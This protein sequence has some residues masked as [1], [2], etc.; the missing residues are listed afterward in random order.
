MSKDLEVKVRSELIR[1]G[2]SLKD[3][4]EIMGISQPYLTDLL[5]GRRTGG[6]AQDHIENIKK[7]LNIK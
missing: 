1:R 3:L 4:A 5:M 2:M 6:K 7:I